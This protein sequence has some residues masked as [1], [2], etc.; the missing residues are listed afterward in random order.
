MRSCDERKERVQKKE[1]EREGV[2]HISQDPTG[3]GSRH[4]FAQRHPSHH[5]FFPEPFPLDSSE[6]FPFP[7]ELAAA[8]AHG[9]NSSQAWLSH[10]FAFHDPSYESVGL[11]G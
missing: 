10:E 11:A 3:R 5:F 2:V 9:S 1:R 8:A 6:D 7:F 4:Q